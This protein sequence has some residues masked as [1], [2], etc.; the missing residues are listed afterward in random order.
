MHSMGKELRIRHPTPELSKQEMTDVVVE[1]YSLSEIL[2]STDR[3][4]HNYLIIRLV[5][6]IEQFFR[7]II[8]MKIK[9]EDSVNYIPERVT[10]DRHTFINMES[11]TKELLIA[12]SYSFQ[13]VNE[14]KQR[15]KEFGM[16]NPFAHTPDANPEKGFEEFF[17]LRHN[18]VHT[19]APINIEIKKYY[20]MTEALIKCVLENVHE[21]KSIFFR[22]KGDALARLDRYDEAIKCCD[23]GL[24]IW[25]KDHIIYLCKGFS[26]AEL[27][28]H[29]EAIES[30]DKGLGIDPKYHPMHVYKGFSLAELGR[31]AEAI[32]CYDK[33]LE[34]DSRDSFVYDSKGISLAELGKLVEAIESY[35]K[36]LELDPKDISACANKGFTLARLG[37][38]A[39]AIES[40]DKGLGIDP[41]YHPMHVYKGLSLAELGKHAEAIE[42]YDKG[43]S[44]DPKDHFAYYSKG[45]S[46]E[47]LGQHD[48]A[49]KCFKE[50]DKLDPD[51]NDP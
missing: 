26:L 20:Q 7:K 45:L 12:S 43:L 24:E 49:K 16:R 51:R 21:D 29:A 30:Y 28:K 36:A 41:K 18:I 44:I 50:S 25:P 10:L 4:M 19:V 40:Y 48:E 11:L 27:G 37:K 47:A 31:H 33:G 14:I 34:I 38:H 39:E 6:I 1:F 23:R 35:D 15:M 13:N 32:E 17:Q 8:E 42:C 2:K 46:F 5:T 22:Y 3:H 9:N